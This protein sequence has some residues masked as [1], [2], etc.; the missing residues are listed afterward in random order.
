MLENGVKR[1]VYASATVTVRFPVDWHDKEYIRCD[2]CDYFRET[3]SRCT[4]TNSVVEFPHQYVGSR[5][6]LE[7]MDEDEVPGTVGG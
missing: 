3:G 4:L 2:K 5:C 7:R 6:P 1:F